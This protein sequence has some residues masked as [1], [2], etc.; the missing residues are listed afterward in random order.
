MPTIPSTQEA[1]LQA[2][3]SLSPEEQR[4]VAKAVNQELQRMSVMGDE[5]KQYHMSRDEFRNRFSAEEQEM[6][7]NLTKVY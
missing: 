5:E 7:G 2:F 6:L 3:R 4:E 1:I